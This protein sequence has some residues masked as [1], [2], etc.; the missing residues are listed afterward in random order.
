MA[1]GASEGGDWLCRG[2]GWADTRFDLDIE[3]SISN[4][5]TQ[6]RAERA[7][8]SKE[9]AAANSTFEDSLLS[10]RP[11]VGTEG[12]LVLRGVASLGA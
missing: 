3:L 11:F 8:M 9:N 1:R 7:Q 12:T 5:G 6:R 4:Q 2:G 10:V